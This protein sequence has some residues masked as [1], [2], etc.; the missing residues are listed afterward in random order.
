MT[1]PSRLRLDEE[2]EH[3]RQYNLLA[4]VKGENTSDYRHVYDLFLKI[5]TDAK[6]LRANKTIFIDPTTHKVNDK[7]INAY[8]KLISIALKAISELNRMRNSD[9]LV[10][11]VLDKHAQT[12]AQALTTNLAVELTRIITGLQNGTMTAQKGAQALRLL[13]HRRLPEFCVEARDEA[14]EQAKTEF[15]LH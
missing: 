6:A 4:G 3:L 7:A 9:K 12:M 11:S 14:Y 13:L 8:A 1:D 5:Y 10:Q 2:E 15:K